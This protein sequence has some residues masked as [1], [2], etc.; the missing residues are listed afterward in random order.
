MTDRELA[1]VRRRVQA[2]LA[3]A[4]R[5]QTRAKYYEAKLRARGAELALRAVLTMISKGAITE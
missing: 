1:A 5:Q 3:A 4:R 2:R